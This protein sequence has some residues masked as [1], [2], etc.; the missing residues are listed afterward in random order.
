[1]RLKN[2]Y[3]SFHKEPEANLVWVYEQGVKINQ[4]F[5]E[6]YHLIKSEKYYDA[7]CEAESV[8]IKIN[9]NHIQI[10]RHYL[11]MIC[12]LVNQASPTKNVVCKT[13]KG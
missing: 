2:Q 10:F 3:V 4:G 6:V 5:V 9:L 8:E 13:L 1:M 12:V 7:W 11:K